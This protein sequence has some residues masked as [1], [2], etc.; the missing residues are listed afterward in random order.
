MKGFRRDLERTVRRVSRVRTI[1]VVEV[2]GDLDVVLRIRVLG[3]AFGSAMLLDLVLGIGVFSCLGFGS[4]R[5]V[6]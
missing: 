4:L 1:W 2:L 5:P 6:V 3:I